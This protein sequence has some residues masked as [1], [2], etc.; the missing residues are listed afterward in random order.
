MGKNSIELHSFR[1]KMMIYAYAFLV[2]FLSSFLL[3]FTYDWLFKNKEPAFLN[4]GILLI[5]LCIS[6][7]MHL[8]S[9]LGYLDVSEHILTLK[10]P[11]IKKEKQIKLE[12]ILTVTKERL[13]IAKGK[14]IK[15]TVYN[16]DKSDT[17]SYH[18]LASRINSL[19]GSDDADYLWKV[20]L[21]R[22]KELSEA[23]KDNILS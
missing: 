12:D 19:F 17:K 8:F 14:H 10:K 16:K 13:L 22:K 4:L 5:L 11:L 3:K 6:L 21:E 7:G 23:H 20:V 18:I 9:Y 1:A 2:L 15:I